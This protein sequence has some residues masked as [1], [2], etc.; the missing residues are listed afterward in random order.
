MN[1][2]RKFIEKYKDSSVIF[3]ASIWFVL[4]T[5]V[6]NCISIITQ[7]FVN[8]ILTVDQVGT[9]NVYTTWATIFQIIATFNLFCGVYEVFLVD[10]KDKQKQVRGSL[11]LLSTII[12]TVFFAFIAVFIDPVSQALGLKPAYLVVMYFFILS[13]EIVQFYIVPL[14][15]NYKYIQYSIF[16]V[17]LFFIKSILTV[18]LSYIMVD[19][20]VLGRILG[21]ALPSFVASTVLFVIMMRSTKKEYLTS[22][23]KQGVKFNLPLVPH[24]LSS[25][26]LASSDKV[27]IQNL[28]SE[29]YVGLYSVVYSFSCLSNIIFT[30]INNSYTPWAYNA[31]KEENCTE[32]KKKTNSII[33]VSVLFSIL[34]MLLAPE[35]IYILGGEKYLEAISIVPILVLGAFLSSFYFIFS[36]VEFINK[37]ANMVF[38]ITVLGAGTNIALNWILIPKLGY[39]AAA[40]T[41][42]IGY[43]V[44]AFCHYYY[45]YRIAKKNLFDMKFIA[46]MLVALFIAS[47]LCIFIY[48]TSLWIRYLLIATFLVTVIFLLKKYLGL[49][50][51]NNKAD[52]PA[53]KE[54]NIDGRGAC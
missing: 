30:A 4:V 45:S 52:T 44:I 39:E 54:E 9:F 13:Q 38:P 49:G 25:V 8:R 23:W 26:V 5:V 2:I 11:C 28:V 14:R 42:V 16:V 32:L 1:A 12:T 18:A 46:S 48:R 35:G 36:N 3:K 19:D 40:Y 6:D 31:I 15:F 50:N 21:L 10:D 34:M 29:Y 47:V 22:Y 33:L 51:K 53:R 7:P 27:M 43:L 24:Y 20:R 17:G 41:T 37:K